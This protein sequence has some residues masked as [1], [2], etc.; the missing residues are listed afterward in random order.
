MKRILGIGLI[1]AVIIVAIFV[2]RYVIKKNIYEGDFWHMIIDS[3][4]F[5]IVIIALILLGVV[6]LKKG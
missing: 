4:E 2:Y 1:V 6:L 3:Y 5:I